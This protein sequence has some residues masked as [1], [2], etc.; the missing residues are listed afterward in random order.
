MVNTITSKVITVLAI[1]LTI[2]SA[3]ESY[4]KLRV[5]KDVL[6]SVFT[7]NFKLILENAEKY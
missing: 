5:Y 7:K 2:A 6:Q 3:F 4:Y 1:S